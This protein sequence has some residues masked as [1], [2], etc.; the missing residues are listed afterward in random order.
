VGHNESNVSDRAT[1]ESPLV[2]QISVLE[3]KKIIANDAASELVDVRTEAE[4]AI[5]TIEGF[6]LLDQAYHDDL[7]KCERDAAIIFQ[8]HHGIRSQHAAE[9]FRQNGFRNLYNVQGGID[10][11]SQLVDPT[12]P[13]Y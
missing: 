12:V 6:R 10:A 3:L 8:C 1:R 5:A 4:R 7:M 11:W 9:Y 13:R 2:R